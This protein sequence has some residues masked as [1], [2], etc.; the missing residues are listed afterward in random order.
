MKNAKKGL[1]CNFEWAHI[2]YTQSMSYH[3]RIEYCALSHTEED[4][5]FGA[6]AVLWKSPSVRAYTESKSLLQLVINLKK[7]KK[8]KKKFFSGLGGTSYC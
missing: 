5:S 6:T 2:Y 8:K 7:V 4:L 3:A 1:F